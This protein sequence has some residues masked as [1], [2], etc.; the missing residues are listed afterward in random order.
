[1]NF[2]CAAEVALKEPTFG[3]VKDTLVPKILLKVLDLISVYASRAPN[4]FN[5]SVHILRGL[6]KR[7]CTV[8]VRRLFLLRSTRE[9]HIITHFYYIN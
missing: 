8:F 2:F 3:I 6:L 1:M 4:C 9:A 7:V 5:L